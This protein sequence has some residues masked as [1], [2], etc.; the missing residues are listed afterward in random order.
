MNDQDFLKC[1]VH[2][3][4]QNNVKIK[5]YQFKEVENYWQNIK[6]KLL[7]G[8]KT[9]APDIQPTTEIK[10]P[11]KMIYVDNVMLWY[12]EYMNTFWNITTY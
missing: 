10:T 5:H 4:R 9:P 3:G 2:V 8:T 1:F 7:D 11:T 12:N 6:K